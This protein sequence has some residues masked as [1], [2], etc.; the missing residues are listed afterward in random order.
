[1]FNMLNLGVSSGWREWLWL[2]ARMVAAEY[3][4]NGL[5]GVEGMEGGVE[6]QSEGVGR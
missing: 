4:V 2:M 6:I 1:M 3:L 5:D